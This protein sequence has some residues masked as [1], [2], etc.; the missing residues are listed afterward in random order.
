MSKMKC[1]RREAIRTMAAGAAAGGMLPLARSRGAQTRP[2]IV[3]VLIDDQRYDAMGFMGKPWLKTPNMDRLAREGVQFENSFVTTSLCSPSRA[4]FLTG[5]YAH[6]HGVMNNATPWLDSNLTFLEILHAQGYR[7]G[8]IGK[9]HMPGEGVPDLANQGK[10]DR[11][12]SFSFGTGQGRYNDCPLIIDGQKTKKKGYITDVL[13]DYALEFLKDL[14]R[15]S[16][17][18][19][20]E[21]ISRPFCLYLS[22][23]AVHAFFNPPKRYEG[24]LKDAPLPRL[25]PQTRDLP[26][27]LINAQQRSRFD[28]NVQGYYEA[29]MAVDDSLGSVLD[30][31]DAKGLSENTLVIYTS[32]NGYFWGEHGLTDK[33]YAYDEA[34]LIPHLIRYPRLIPEGG[35]K[36]SEMVL[37]IDLAPTVLSA[38]GIEPP[39]VMQGRSWLDLAQGRTMPWRDSFLYEYFRDPAF[40]NPRIKAV[41]TREWKYITYPDSKYPDEMYNLIED[42][43]EKND[44]AFDPAYADK[45]NELIGE[46]KRLEK[47]TSC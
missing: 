11:M 28:K 5:R 6:C 24:V 37:N 19:D 36:V 29:L 22:H 45:K 38:A 44:L 33:R 8:F 46:L 30:Y 14:D 40:P 15:Y 7:T 16:Y 17:D 39:P 18:E 25:E 42:P 27:G 1:N 31:L 9:W 47:E 2:N 21:G 12:V 32:D 41:R 10:V 26:L 13:T 43:R 34:L 23:K 20:D 3:F 4:S 35:K